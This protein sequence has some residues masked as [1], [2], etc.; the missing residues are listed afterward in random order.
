MSVEFGLLS[1]L[2]SAI[3]WG[4][5]FVPMKKIENVNPFQYQAFMVTG[6]FLTTLI[7]S[8]FLKFPFNLNVFGFS[9]GI[10]WTIGNALS[11]I[12]VKR[13][14]LGRSSAIWMSVA[15]LVS[16]IWGILFFQEVLKSMIVGIIGIILIILG[17][18]FVLYSGKD[19]DK[20]KIGLVIAIIAGVFFGSQL[21][22]FKLSSLSSQEFLFPMSLGILVSGWIMFLMRASKIEGYVKQGLVS[23]GIWN[24]A[25][26][27]SLFAVSNLGISIGF[28][29]TQMALLVAVLWGLLYFKEIKGKSSKVKIVIGAVIMIVGA[30]A[31]AF[32]K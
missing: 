27:F 31:L 9:S 26:L 20:R 11:A 29:L 22:P 32:A 17:I 24:V 6:I 8:L 13:S 4:T 16:F 5:Y 1:A 2:I 25:N 30:M 7:I 18:I 14:G 3:C 23:G 10:I 21:V 19:I 12:A 28:P 15:V